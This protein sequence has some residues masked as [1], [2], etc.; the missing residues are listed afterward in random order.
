M[1]KVLIYTIV[2]A[3]LTIVGCRPAD[4]K[5]IGMPSDPLGS[6]AGNWK[7]VKVIQ[8]D[9]QAEIKNSPYVS[10]DIT[11]LF[12]YSTLSLKLDIANGAPAQYTITPGAAPAIITGNA[13][14][15][16]LDNNATPS[17]AWFISGTDTTIMQ[18]S[19]YPRSFDQ[20][21][22]MKVER[23]EQPSGKLATSYTY[24]FVKQ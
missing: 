1:R 11:G 10:E 20:G 8:K 16:V 13:G 15:W 7:L 22:Q 19:S 4:Y 9:E 5:E 23:K 24:D 17:K 6:L 18:I 3:V 14:K 12:A 2:A 21:F